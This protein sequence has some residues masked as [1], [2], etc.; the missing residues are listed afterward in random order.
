MHDTSSANTADSA[1]LNSHGL[2]PQPAF[3]A[4]PLKGSSLHPA[5]RPQ[6]VNYTARGGAA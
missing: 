2:S 6:P 5:P 1:K 3:W 4:R